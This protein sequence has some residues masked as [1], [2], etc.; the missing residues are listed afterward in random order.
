MTAGIVTPPLLNG[1]NLTQWRPEPTIV[2][3]MQTPQGEPLLASW[4]VELGQVAAFTSDADRWA[5]PWQGWEGYARL[6]TQIVRAVS[7][8]AEDGRLELATEVVGDRL[9]VRLEAAGRDGR[10][11]DLLSVPVTLYAP[12]GE[13]RE[14]WLS[15]TGP[16][17]YEAA[18][19]AR[20]SGTYVTVAKPRLGTMRLTPVVAGTSLASGIEYRVLRSDDALLRRMAEGSGGRVLNLA[21]MEAAAQVFERQGVAATT[22]RTPL[23]DTLLVWTLGMLLLDVGTRRV[24]W[25]RLVSRRFGLGLKEAATEAVRDRGAAAARAV[26]RL[27]GGVRAEWPTTK[28]SLGDDDAKRLAAREA[29]RRAQQRLAA[30]RAMREE[31]ARPEAKA[32]PAKPEA[33]ASSGLL[34]AKRRAKERFGGEESAADTQRHREEQRE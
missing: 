29:D 30:L 5:A 15:Q 31:A 27:R 6:W 19:E 18:A 12:S 20:E 32:E 8:S 1:V 25:D 23:W 4:Q 3:A 24:A 21:D 13:T 28:G 33:E 26:E 7:R 16:G 17:L 14:L 22:A 10:P 34:A 2:R 9:R 11:L